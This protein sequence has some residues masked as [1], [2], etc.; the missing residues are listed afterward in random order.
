[1]GVGLSIRG[2]GCTA[3]ICRDVSWVVKQA[4]LECAYVR[5]FMQES[6]VYAQALKSRHWLL[7][8]SPQDFLFMLRRS[9]FWVLCLGL[10][11]PF[12]EVLIISALQTSRI[13]QGAFASTTVKVRLVSLPRYLHI[14]LPGLKI[15]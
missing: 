2:C 9:S 4:E 13:L 5:R 7:T 12:A 15:H 10:D 6:N 3:G 1:M 11:G 14:V 8:S